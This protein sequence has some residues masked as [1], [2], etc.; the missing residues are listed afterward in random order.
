MNSN[1]YPPANVPFFP[2]ADEQQQALWQ[3]FIRNPQALQT[4][5]QMQS[6][7]PQNNIVPVNQNFLSGNMFPVSSPMAFPAQAEID[8][9]K[10]PGAQLVPA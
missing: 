4:L 7:F 3:Q 5:L 2:A 8:C 10:S 9:M 6:G 1:Q